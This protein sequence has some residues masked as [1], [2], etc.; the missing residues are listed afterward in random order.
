M[1]MFGTLGFIDYN[2]GGAQSIV[3]LGAQRLTLL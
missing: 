3:R 1:N 2:S